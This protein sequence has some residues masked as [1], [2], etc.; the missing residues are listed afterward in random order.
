M[1][2]DLPKGDVRNGNMLQLWECIGTPSQQW[3]FSPGTWQIKY[4]ANPDKC[5]DVPE[6]DYYEGARLQLWDCNGLSQQKWGY[7]WKSMKTI[8]LAASLALNGTQAHRSRLASNGTFSGIGRPLA[9]FCLSSAGAE[10]GAAIQ[11]SR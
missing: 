1:C 3:K 2:L 11:L 6:G 5:I 10:N 7:D 8:Y 4:A 9:S